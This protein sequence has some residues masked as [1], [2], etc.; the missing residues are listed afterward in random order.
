[1]SNNYSNAITQKPLTPER[2]SDWAAFV[3]N[4]P[5]GTAFHSLAWKEAI[6]QVMDY[7]SQYRLWYRGEK[8]VAAIP[9]FRTPEIIGSSVV[10]PF[11]AHGFPLLATDAGSSQILTDLASILRSR[12][13]TRIIKERQGTQARGYNTSGYGGI[14]TGVT[15]RLSVNVSYDVLWNDLFEPSLRKNVRAAEKYG[16]IVKECT[17]LDQYYEL[18]LQT[19]QRLGSPQFSKSFFRELTKQFNEDCQLIGAFLNGE[20]VAGILALDH[21]TERN[22]FTAASDPTK[23]K[24]RPNEILY[25]EI[26]R[27]ATKG[28]PSVVDFGRTEPGSGVYAF[29]KQ[30]GADERQLMSFVTP[31][32]RTPKASI[33]RYKRLASLTSIVTPVITHSAI[34]PRLK[35]WIHE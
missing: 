18:Y 21:P 25:T 24:Y 15:F 2:E 31:P 17:D 27:N 6:K 11:C 8:L 26:L 12:F 7:E 35:R 14:Q 1:M 34:G 16:I 13:E 30:F 9:A 22:L 10:Q 3:Q 20:M 19:M 23:W 28:S 29:K 5:S 33:S 4:H 32:Q